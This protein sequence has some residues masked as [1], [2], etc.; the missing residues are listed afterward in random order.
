[1]T[2]FLC[3]SYGGVH[4][5][6]LYIVLYR[7][8]IAHPNK[9]VASKHI[10]L[11]PCQCPPQCL[12][13][14]TLPCPPYWSNLKHLTLPVRVTQTGGPNLQSIGWASWCRC[15]LY[16]WGSSCSWLQNIQSNNLAWWPQILLGKYI[17]KAFS[18][19]SFHWDR[20]Q[21]RKILLFSNVP[22]AHL[23]EVEKEAS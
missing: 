2:V 7:A 22:D 18:Q 4:G 6:E 9:N 5:M 15:Q 8:C 13:H 12:T 11:G 3:V 16:L 17:S 19:L 21:A 1:M 23:K 10:L 20:P 14:L